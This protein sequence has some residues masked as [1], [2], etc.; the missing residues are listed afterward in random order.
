MNF[1]VPKAGFVLTN[2]HVQ[3]KYHICKRRTLPTVLSTKLHMMKM[4]E[5]KQRLVCSQKV[6]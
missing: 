3:V 2:G 6:H 5:L 1:W 4:V